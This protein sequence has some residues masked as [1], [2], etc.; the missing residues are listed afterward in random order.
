MS[1][2]KIVQK[3]DGDYKGRG[4][5]YSKAESSALLDV[6]A[7]ILPTTQADW[8]E[9]ARRH[10]QHFS[11]KK[12]DPTSLETKLRKLSQYKVGENEVSQ[13]AIFAERAKF[14]AAKIKRRRKG[15][16]WYCVERLANGVEVFADEGPLFPHQAGSAPASP[17][18]ED[19]TAAAMG[20]TAAATGPTAAATGPSVAAT[21]GPT[22][23]ASGPTTTVAITPREAASPVKAVVHKKK[24]PAIK[25]QLLGPT[26][27]PVG[28]TQVL[29]LKPPPSGSKKHDEVVVK[30][31]FMLENSMK[32]ERDLRQRLE[33]ESEHHKKESQRMEEEWRKE[34]EEWE[35]E[36]QSMFKMML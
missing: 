5:G 10:V 4:Y 11:D 31:N 25:H 19:M 27:I 2:E 36:R 6:V 12:R 33:K 18:L 34:R 24:A 21:T 20:P 15:E 7:R 26:G 35:K 14:L 1:T 16:T 13:N 30:L 22:A 23:V 8:E 17:P 28:Q 3:V 29:D 32:R 9:V